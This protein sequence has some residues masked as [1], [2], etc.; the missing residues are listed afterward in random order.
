MVTKKPNTVEQTFPIKAVAR[1]T[2][3]SPDLIRAWERRYGLV[4]PQR[5]AGRNRV[6]TRQDISRLALV[7]RLVDAGDR[8]STVAGLSVDQL[9]DRLATHEVQHA[10]RWSAESATTY[11]VVVVGDVIPALLTQ[12]GREL[13]GFEIVGVYRNPARFALEVASLRPELLV[14]E[15][16]SI[17][18]DTADEIHE[19]VASSRA[20]RALVVY[21]FGTQQAVS[22]LRTDRFTLLRAPVDLPGLREAMLQVLQP[23]TAPQLRP[24]RLPVGSAR[25]IA[26]RRYDAQMLARIATASNTVRCACPHHL[27]ELISKLVA[28]EQYS[29]D[30]ESRNLEDA[31]LHSL[32]HAT[33]ANARAMIEEALAWVV[34]Q[35]KI[36][37]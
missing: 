32:L 21:G 28:F 14:L 10:E 24:S 9:E 25:T 35:E 5:T 22:R 27:V 19:L 23:P 2:G 1:M 3:I 18:Q 7:K 4:E 8:V 20:A 17:H 37:Y 16:P 13:P 15:Y 29:A 6:Y 31:A 12:T 33:T 34:E 30:C 11:R 36:N 26:P